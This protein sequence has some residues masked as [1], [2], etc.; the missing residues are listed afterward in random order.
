MTFIEIYNRIINHWGDKIDFSDGVLFEPDHKTPGTTPTDDK[1]FQSNLFSKQ[2]D[3]IEEIVGTDDT[4]GDLMV[5]TMYQVFHRHAVQLFQKN[6][7]QLKPTDIDKKEIEEQYFNN[8]NAESWEEELL[9][10]KRVLE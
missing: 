4:Y 8:L 2:W 6:I 10:Y 9:N 7:Y 1:S 5:W 3:N